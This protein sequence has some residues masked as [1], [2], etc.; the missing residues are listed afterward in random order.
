MVK[1]GTSSSYNQQPIFAQLGIM[2]LEIKTIVIK[3]ALAAFSWVEMIRFE[4]VLH[5]HYRDQSL[6]PEENYVRDQ[7]DCLLMICN[8]KMHVNAQGKV[9]YNPR[10]HET[11][12]FLLLFLPAPCNPT[13]SPATAT[14]FRP[15]TPVKLGDFSSF[16]CSRT[17][18]KPKKLPDLLCSSSLVR[19]LFP[20]GAISGLFR[21]SH[22]H[23]IHPLSLNLAWVTLIL[24]LVLEFLE[25][26]REFPPKSRQLPCSPDPAFAC[27]KILEVKP[28]TGKPRGVTR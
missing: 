15:G 9:E 16:S 1:S 7:T 13:S 4:A 23:E 25:F 6:I 17:P 28:R 12:V 14:H 8:M 11:R 19:E 2:L 3:K 18:I 10:V 26:C 21:V 5:R 24:L 20:L 27:R 22:S